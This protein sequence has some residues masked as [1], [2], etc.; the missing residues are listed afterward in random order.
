MTTFTCRTYYLDDSDPFDYTKSGFLEPPKPPRFAFLT[1]ICLRT[2][3]PG[4]HK[5]LDA[6]HKVYFRLINI[7]IYI[8][9]VRKLHSPSIPLWSRA[10]LFRYLSGYGFNSA[11]AMGGYKRVFG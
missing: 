11:R 9:L 2:Q 3:L 7:S 5:I 4:L 10:K 1:D 6:P 8:F